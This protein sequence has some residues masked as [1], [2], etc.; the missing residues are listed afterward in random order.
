MSRILSNNKSNNINNNANPIAST[1]DE[2]R[3]PRTYWP[4]RTETLRSIAAVLVLL[5]LGALITGGAD[6]LLS[7]VLDPILIGRR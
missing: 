4:T 6:A 3:P 5:T 1:L 2:L 7:R